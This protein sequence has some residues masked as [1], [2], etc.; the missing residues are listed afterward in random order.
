MKLIGSPKNGLTLCIQY[1][2]VIY[3]GIQLMGCGVL[4]KHYASVPEDPLPNTSI[5]SIG[6]DNIIHFGWPDL[7]LAIQVQNYLYAGFSMA[8][9]VIVPIIPIWEREGQ[10]EEGRHLILWVDIEPKDKSNAF[11]FD[12]GRVTL[13]FDDGTNVQVKE[14]VGPFK[15]WFSPR[16]V[17]RGCGKRRYSLGV[18]TSRSVVGQED[19]QTPH[20][21]I[22]IPF[23]EKSFGWWHPEEGHS[24]FLLA[25]DTNGSPDRSFVL[26]IEGIEKGGRQYPVPETRFKKGSI[27]K[28]YP[29]P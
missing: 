23:E 11:S 10:W 27:W 1:L 28:S 9:L 13:R 8:Q 12:P 6:P 17:V 18:A 15:P 5:T 7:D 22:P 4:V 21:S 29:V 3:L 16:A 24:C 26:S 25:F 19:I 14:F 20:G 2:A